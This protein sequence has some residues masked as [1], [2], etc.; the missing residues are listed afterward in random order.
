MKTSIEETLIVASEHQDHAH[1]ADWHA[2]LAGA[3]FAASLWVLFGTFGSSIGLSMASPYRGEGA[4]MTLFAVAIGLWSVWTVLTSVMAG[5]YLA[6]RL[7]RRLA[8]TRDHEVT[9]RDG[10]HGLIV[11][12][13]SALMATYLLTTITA[14]VAK[15][16]TAAAATGALAAEVT[17][18]GLRRAVDPADPR[19]GIDLDAD[20]LLRS[21]QDTGEAF[22][23]LWAASAQA[24]TL[25]P[26]DQQY[27]ADVVSTR[28]GVPMEEANA[29]VSQT[30][31]HAV[32]LV[33]KARAEAERARKIGVLASF[34]AAASLVIAAGGAWWA[35][36]LGGRHRDE[37]TDFSRLTG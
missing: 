10:I 13:L 17:P 15:A 2:I 29:R 27:L 24:G 23:R 18:K 33:S 25:Q 11:W 35:A 19:Q 31:A 30:F 5:G 4:S 36:T 7:R 22:R 34:L 3:V 8:S 20:K 32:E 12:A 26:D 6:G 14:T 1:L 16:G 9:V 28:S 37:R 21:N